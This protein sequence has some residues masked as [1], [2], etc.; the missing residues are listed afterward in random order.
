MLLA[1][2]TVALTLTRMAMPIG[3][4]E[5]GFTIRTA[6]VAPMQSHH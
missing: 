2:L 3:L 5:P 4:H 1:R 6:V